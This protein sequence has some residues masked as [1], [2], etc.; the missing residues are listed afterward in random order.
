MCV[1]SGDER[2][3]HRA[4]RGLPRLRAAVHREQPPTWCHV[5]LPGAGCQPGRGEMI[6]TFMG[7][8]GG[9]E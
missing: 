9:E 7:G 6:A 2:R 3:R 1:Q 4:S 5:Q 8:G